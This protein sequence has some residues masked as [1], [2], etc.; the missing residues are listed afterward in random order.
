[1]RTRIAFACSAA[2]LASIAGCTASAPSPGPSSAADATA[3]LAG[4]NETLLKFGILGNRGGWVAQNFITEDT[5]ALNAR[6]SQESIEATVKLAKEAT[7][8]DAITLPDLERRQ[9]NVLKTS[10][11]MVTPSDSKEAEEITTIMGRLE[12]AYG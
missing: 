1:M 3:F 11:V 7:K 2:L 4:A 5:A 6:I 10:L 12:A 9:L 8:F